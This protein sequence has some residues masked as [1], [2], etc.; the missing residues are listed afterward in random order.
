MESGEKRG[1]RRDGSPLI[2]S[3]P[4][5]EGIWPSSPHPLS[6]NSSW[7]G[8]HGNLETRVLGGEV[9]VAAL[10]GG[11]RSLAWIGAIF[12]RSF[13]P[14]VLLEPGFAGLLGFSVCAQ[15]LPAAGGV[16]VSLSYSPPIRLGGGSLG[17]VSLG[18]RFAG[19][20]SPVLKGLGIC[21]KK[22]RSCDSK[23]CCKTS[24]Q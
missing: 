9:C 15:S 5:F 11:C 3:P 24:L 2:S 19:R 6:F 23:G 8:L 10:P 4:Q 1:E 17:E 13:V 20:F 12:R 7:R 22:A 21:E 14:N 16:P 18:R